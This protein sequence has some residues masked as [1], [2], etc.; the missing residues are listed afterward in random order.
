MNALVRSR[1]KEHAYRS[2]VKQR[3]KERFGI[4]LGRADLEAIRAFILSGQAVEV[5]GDCGGRSMWHMN[6][7]GHDVGVV[8]DLATSTPVTILSP[9]MAAQK[10]AHVEKKRA[11][12]VQSP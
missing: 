6:V 2:H 3:M 11:R 7:A 1:M 9:K 8:F 5:L 4:D 10:I 12:V